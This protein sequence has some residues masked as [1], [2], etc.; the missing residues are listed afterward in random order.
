[1]AEQTDGKFFL[2]HRYALMLTIHTQ[3]LT[4]EPSE[5]EEDSIPEP[6]PG[7]YYYKRFRVDKITEGEQ[8][9][10]IPHP[11]CVRSIHI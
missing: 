1:M 4:R 6:E 2:P 7:P 5:D 9:E 10:F 11:S 3:R 8:M